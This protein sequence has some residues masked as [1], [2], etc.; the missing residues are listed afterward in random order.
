ML[1]GVSADVIRSAPCP[2]LV[3]PRGAHQAGENDP[4]RLEEP[5]SSGEGGRA[6]SR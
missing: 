1:G 6:G 4:F 2:V 5:A 3:A